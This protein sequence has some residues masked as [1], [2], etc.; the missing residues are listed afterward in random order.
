LITPDGGEITI[1]GVRLAR[2]SFQ[3]KQK[4]GVLP[5]N[6]GLFDALT[7][8][9]HLE[10]VGPIYG[11]GKGETGQRT[12][13]LLALFDLERSRNTFAGQCSHGMRKKL[14]LAMALL[15]NPRVLLL[16][17]PFEGIDPTSVQSIQYLLTK[18]AL[19]GVTVLLTSH[20][21]P[22]IEQLTSQIV[23]L[24]QGRVVWSS[25]NQGSGQSLR[26]QYF[27]RVEK[28]LLEDLP[29]LGH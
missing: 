28:P 14:S 27:D 16:D 18:I 2:S 8:K 10:L 5:E 20:L 13:A 1:A 21:L 25:A 19:R 29:W 6:L 15:H 17:E 9:E 3:V 22:T 24:Q 23:V 12:D 11:L 26:K 7:V 4:I